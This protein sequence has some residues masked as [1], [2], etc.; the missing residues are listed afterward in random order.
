MSLEE[1]NTCLGVMQGDIARL[2]RDKQEG[3]SIDDAELQKELGNFI[4][5]T[6]RWCDDLGFAPETC[7]AAA[8]A[9]QE[10][11]VAARKA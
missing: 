11:Y 7:L 9:A 5:S 2:A 3:K 1:I 8:Q 6:I 10:R 4:F